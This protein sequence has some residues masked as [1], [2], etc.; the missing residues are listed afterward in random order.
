MSQDMHK[1][2][3]K[4][5]WADIGDETECIGCESGID[6]STA[7]QDENGNYHPNCHVDPEKVSEEQ[8]LLNDTDTSS[9]PRTPRTPRSPVESQSERSNVFIPTV[10]V[11]LRLPIKVLDRLVFRSIKEEISHSFGGFRVGVYIHQGNE[12]HFV[13]SIYAKDEKRF[14][15]GLY[16]FV[17]NVISGQIKRGQYRKAPSKRMHGATAVKTR[18]L[19]NKNT[20]VKIEE[21][22][23]AFCIG[24]NKTNI[25]RI[26]AE[27]KERY[28][29][30]RPFIKVPRKQDEKKGVFHLY[31]NTEKAL[32][33]MTDSLLEIAERC[34]KRQSRY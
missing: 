11:L 6:N 33:Y 17:Q 27:T 21:H 13:L 28:E 32:V 14:P 1:I 31:A 23:I 5:N 12:T 10:E 18:T 2:N 9:T 25:K 29:N 7:H 19:P 3:E 16:D 22:A 4:T 34:E 24:K 15:R 20:E 8:E 26:I 30:S